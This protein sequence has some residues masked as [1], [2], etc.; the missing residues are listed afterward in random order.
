MGVAFFLDDLLVTDSEETDSSTTSSG[1]G[2]DYQVGAAA[3]VYS[4]L[5]PLCKTLFEA[6]F[7]FWS[8][9]LMLAVYRCCIQTTAEMLGRVYSILSKRHGRVISEDYQ[10]GTGFFSITARLPVV[11]SFGLADDIRSRT[12]GVAIPQLSFAGFD[13][14]PQDPFWVPTTEDELVEF[15]EQG[16]ENPAMKYLV[17]IRERKGL[18]VERKIVQ[19][20]EKQRTL[21]R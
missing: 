11:E 10:D 6:A 4:Q 21:K 2:E 13:V 19:F 5:I 8:P 3:R 17:A 12:A 14:L 15:G 9:R 7:S 20:A 16:I 1:D 18:Y